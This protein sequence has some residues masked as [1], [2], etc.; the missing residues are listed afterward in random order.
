MLSRTAK[1]TTPCQ[2]AGDEPQQKS[3]KLFLY[4]YWLLLL[5]KSILNLANRIFADLHH[6][7]SKKASHAL[8]AH[9]IYNVQSAWM[10]V[11]TQRMVIK[12]SR[13]K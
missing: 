8:L 5:R 11:I 12:L 4:P 13:M 7:I 10:F 9:L 2:S 3:E 6:E 1:Q